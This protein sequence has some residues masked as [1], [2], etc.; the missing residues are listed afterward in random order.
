MG[1]LLADNQPQKVGRHERPFGACA[2]GSGFLEQLRGS[3]LPLRSAENV[4][5]KA[6]L[7]CLSVALLW[8]FHVT[9]G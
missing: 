7:P 4:G 3:A 8:D 9:L 2:C 5:M 6:W 1:S